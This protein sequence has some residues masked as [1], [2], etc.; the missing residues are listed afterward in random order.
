[1]I[2]CKTH[3]ILAKRW[4][5]N[6]IKSTSLNFNSMLTGL[7]APCLISIF[8]MCNGSMG[9]KLMPLCPSLPLISNTLFDTR[10]MHSV[11]PIGH[12]SISAAKRWRIEKERERN[13]NK[14][15]NEATKQCRRRR[16]RGRRWDERSFCIRQKRNKNLEYF[17]F[18]FFFG[19]RILFYA[20]IRLNS[21]N[22]IDS[23]WVWGE[24]CNLCKSKLINSGPKYS[25]ESTLSWH[26]LFVLNNVRDL[27]QK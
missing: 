20:E 2:K 24:V 7:S 1:M 11:S 19:F 14:R 13:E 23:V 16:W 6:P 3:V 22:G 5:V 12:R 15:E 25:G 27:A 26:F 9:S 8:G 17:Y 10:R 21:L 4:S 18:E